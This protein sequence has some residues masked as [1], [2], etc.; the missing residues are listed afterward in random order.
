[1]LS[2]VLDHFGFARDFYGAGYYET[3][4]HRQVLQNLRGAIQC[5]ATDRLHRA[6]RLRQDPAASPV[7]GYSCRGEARHRVEIACRRQG[8][9]QPDDAD[10]SAFL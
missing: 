4:Y 7:A 5:R 9:H 10:H 1:M 2:E 8:A 6:G 3:P